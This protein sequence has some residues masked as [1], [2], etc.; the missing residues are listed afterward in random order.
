VVHETQ[1]PIL[2]AAGKSV[3]PAPDDLLKT[4]T[5]GE[6]AV[7]TPAAGQSSL[8]RLS[9]RRPLSFLQLLGPGLVTGASDDDP[10]GIGT[11]AQVGSQF[12]YGFLW[13][14]WLTF[15]LMAAVQETCAR[16]ALQTGVGLGQSLRRKFPTS[17][18]G[19]CVSALLVANTINVGADLG[20]IVPASSCCS[21]CRCPQP[22]FWPR[23]R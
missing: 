15:P 9:W 13:L 11:Y 3:E 12:G 18:V 20:A 21:P 22:C 6:S 1:D 17:L 5:R 19:V 2:R 4:L 23:S 16:V 7:A 10:S 8:D 14:A